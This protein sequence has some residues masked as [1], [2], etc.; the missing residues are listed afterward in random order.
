MKKN[1]NPPK[2]NPQI[3]KHLVVNGANRQFS[4][5]VTKMASKHLRVFDILS[6]Q[7]NRLKLL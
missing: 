4:K 2:P 3:A 5:E 7:G 6:H 1:K